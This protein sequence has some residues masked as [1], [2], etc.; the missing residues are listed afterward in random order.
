MSEYLHFT[1]EQKQAARNADLL[2][3]VRRRGYEVVKHGNSEYMLK[4]HD[5]IKIS[6]NLW[7]RY[8]QQTVDAN[9][10]L[11]YEGGNTLDFAMKF[12]GL[13][14]VEA[15]KAI[16]GQMNY[17]LPQYHYDYSKKKEEKDVILP[18][19]NSDCKHV[20]AYLCKTR[21]IDEDV[22]RS[23]LKQKIL[24]ESR[25]HHNCVFV[26]ND[27]N[28]TARYG[29]IRGTNSEKRFVQEAKYST[30]SYGLVIPGKSDTVYVFEAIIDAMSHATMT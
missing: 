13:N 14:F 8:S 5:S 23:L 24:Y 3:Y 4:E 30:K 26:A 7:C 6:N 9:G 16:G 10:E 18:E 19:P 28:G 27:E 12:E 15:M 11:S 2:D 21:C 29:F 22:V 25:E 17:G 20:F 1:E